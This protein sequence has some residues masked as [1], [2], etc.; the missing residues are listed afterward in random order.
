MGI[1]ADYDS[2]PDLLEFGANPEEHVAALADLPLRYDGDT[3]EFTLRPSGRFSNSRGYASLASNYARLDSTA[4][5]SNELGSTTLEGDLSRDS[6]L[7][8]AG[9][10]VNGVGVRRDTALTS[11][12]WTRSLTERLQAQL[13]ASWSTVHYDQPAGETA[14]VDYRYLSAGPTVTYSLTERDNLKLLGSIGRY[15]SLNGITDSHSTSLQLGWTRQL[16]EIWSLSTTAG[17]SR[18]KNSEQIYFGPFYLGDYLTSQDGAVYSAVLTRQGEAV[19]LNFS[20]SRTLQPS[21]FAYL[22][23]Q[24][25][26]SVGATYKRSERWDF[27]LGGTWQTTSNPIARGG[28]VVV[29]Y[30]NAQF[31]ANWHCTERWT[32]SLH[33]TQISQQYG[34]PVIGTASSGVSVDIMRQFLRTQL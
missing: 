7:Y 22:S 34:S 32:V 3:V 2:N 27:S 16:S 5:F 12:D 21:G 33:V 29:H 11:G 8:Y 6:S 1:S 10:L 23:L 31:A 17:Y 15:Q 18:S 4:Q 9:G 13:D 19:N 24:N 28:E 20:G 30:L 25:S 26:L 14:L